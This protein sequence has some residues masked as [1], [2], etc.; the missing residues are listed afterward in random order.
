MTR[1]YRNIYIYM[2][3]F[4]VKLKRSE[5]YAG[6]MDRSVDQSD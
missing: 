5:K 2:Y 3:I 1:G 6:E 4:R